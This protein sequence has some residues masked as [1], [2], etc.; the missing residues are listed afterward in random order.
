[1]INIYIYIL[2]SKFPNKWTFQSAPFATI[3]YIERYHSHILLFTLSIEAVSLLSIE[4]INFAFVL[5]GEK[6][7]PPKRIPKRFLKQFT[8]LFVALTHFNQEFI[9]FPLER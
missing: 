1:M 4:N 2:P 8:E 3:F 7:F 5:E 6:K 9:L